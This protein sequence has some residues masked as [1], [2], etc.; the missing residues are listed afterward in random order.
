MILIH[1]KA[2]SRDDAKLFELAATY[3]L[4]MDRK[5][6]L[7]I[8]DSAQSVLRNAGVPPAALHHL[9]SIGLLG[10]GLLVTVTPGKK[11]HM[12]YHGSDC[13][14]EGRE[15]HAESSTWISFYHFTSIGTEI[16][17]LCDLVYREDYWAA[18]LSDLESEPALLVTRG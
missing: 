12:S 17:Q 16:L 4:R 7:L 14:V 18:V 13:V 15:G 11:I 9:V 6:V 3:A 5:T 1:A 8:S 2:F 10:D